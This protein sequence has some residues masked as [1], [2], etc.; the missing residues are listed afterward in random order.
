MSKNLDLFAIAAC[1]NGDAL[2]FETDCSDDLSPSP[3]A[4]TMQAEGTGAAGSKAVTGIML[5]WN[6]VSSV[7]GGSG[8]FAFRTESIL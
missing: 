8:G 2:S 7:A 5:I 1:K 4:F 6:A 3:R